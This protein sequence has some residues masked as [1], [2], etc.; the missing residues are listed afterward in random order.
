MLLHS[1]QSNSKGPPSPSGAGGVAPS[2]LSLGLDDGTAS[3]AASLLASEAAALATYVTVI[4][5]TSTKGPHSASPE[6]P[7]ARVEGLPLEGFG[8]FL[9]QVGASGALHHTTRS[10]GGS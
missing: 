10:M 5:N 6:K 7:G 9:I 1:D 2:A 4:T 8:P 3:P